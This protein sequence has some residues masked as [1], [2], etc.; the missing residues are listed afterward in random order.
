[1]IMHVD[2]EC[3]I[4]PPYIKAHDL[5]ISVLTD[6]GAELQRLNANPIVH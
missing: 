4:M 5:K 3:I 2:L 6:D 1:M